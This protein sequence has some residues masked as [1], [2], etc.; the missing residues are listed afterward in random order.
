[1]VMARN[2]GQE[3]TDYYRKVTDKTKVM[4][5]EGSSHILRMSHFR[6]T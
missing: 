5:I 3:E 6:L 1:M 2:S 4:N